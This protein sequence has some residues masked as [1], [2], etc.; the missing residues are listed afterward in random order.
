VALPALESLHRTA[1]AG[2]TGVPQRYLV[3]FGGISIG[4]DGTDNVAPDIV[5]PGYDVKAGIAPLGDFGVQDDVSVVSG[6]LTPWGTAMDGSDVPPAGRLPMMHNS[7]YVPLY[8]GVRPQGFEKVRGPSSDQIVGAA[9]GTG[10]NVP[11]MAYRVQAVY[12]GGDPSEAAM[13]YRVGASGAIEPVTPKTS[14]EL[15]F[16]EL[17]SGFAPGDDPDAVAAAEYAKRRRLSVL[18]LVR[19]S[20]QRLVARV[21][22]ADRLRIEQ[23]LD[24]VRELEQRVETITP[25]AGGEGCHVPAE[26]VDPELSDT[27]YSDEDT[28]A[29]LLVELVALAFICDISRAGSLMFT[30]PQC[31]LHLQP[32]TGT[33]KTLHDI[34]HSSDD[35]GQPGQRLQQMTDAIAWHVRHFARLVSLLRDA[36]ESDGRS[37]LDHSALVLVFEGGHGFD[38]M[39]GGEVH[40]TENMSALIAGRAGGLAPG[41]HVVT[42][43]AHPSSVILSAM[44]AVGV[45][46]DFGE[47][48]EDLPELIA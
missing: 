15:V 13:S 12:G 45:Q 27:G 7:C 44:H 28:R 40:S 9:I 38:P 41:R 5:G 30:T 43:E 25:G 23:H 14:P 17:F 46:G 20:T 24:Y 31:G 3:A 4:R 47:V 16:G 29:E 8:C 19:D 10:T 39:G 32:F 11:T 48:T 26:P 34:G 18:D 21:S 42:N 33:D 1:H 22:A 37:V 6:L 35:P 2:G 36:P